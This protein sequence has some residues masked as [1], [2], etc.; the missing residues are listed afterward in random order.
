MRGLAALFILFT[1]LVTVFDQVVQSPTGPDLLAG[2]LG[3]IALVLAG[4]WLS[5]FKRVVRYG[6]PV[7][8]LLYILLHGSLYASVR[9]YPDHVLAAVPAFLMAIA[10]TLALPA[11]LVR[12][13]V[14][15]AALATLGYA[16]RMVAFMPGVSYT[17]PIFYVVATFLTL[18][19][20]AYASERG[21]RIAWASARAIA[22]EKARSEAL[23]LNVLPPSIAERM[24]AGERLIADTH[25][26][27]TIL[28][29]DIVGFTP[30]S[31]RLDPNELVALLDQ[32][33]TR[34]DAIADRHDLEKIKTIGDAYMLAAGAPADR[35]I[36]PERVCRAALDMRAAIAGIAATLDAPLSMR[37]GI[38][39]GP[40]VA[41]VIGQRKFIYDIWG[42]TVNTASRMESTAPEGE[43][44]V[45]EAVATRLAGRFAFT[46]RGEIEVKGLGRMPAFLL[47]AAMPD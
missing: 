29:A 8:A 33:F 42:D 40:V 26:F 35:A 44:Q 25:E 15:I 16:E 45:T 32:V 3:A 17:V 19:Y 28:F 5:R 24:N 12:F 1:A 43:I 20:G 11:L 6:Q 9:Y 27:A 37:V 14:P 13:A 34:F 21:R 7:M 2:R 36:E 41:G 18:A 22:R 4:V 39:A 47:G 10:M 46:A 31:R 38:H 30:L 23:L